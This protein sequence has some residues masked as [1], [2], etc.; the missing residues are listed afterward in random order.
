MAGLEF[1]VPYNNDPETLN[2]IFKL[3][4]MGKNMIREVYLSGPQIYSG[5]GRITLELT[6]NQFKEIIDKIHRHRIRVNLIINPTCEGGD[7]YSRDVVKTK[8]DFLKQMHEEHGLE[9]VTIANPIYVKE[10]RRRFPN[11]EICASVLGDIDSVQR[12]VIYNKLGAN[13]IT[14]D[15][16]INR[17]LDL[18]QKIKSSVDAELKL[19]VNDGCLH[20]CPFRRFHFNYMSH[21][22]KDLTAI[23]GDVFFANCSQITG[24]DHSQIL[25][26]CWIR[27]EDTK[28]YGEITNFFKIVGRARPKSFVIRVVKAY[29]RQSWDGD[30][31]D[32]VS[33]SLN[34]YGI[35]YGAHLDNKSLGK[36]DFFEKVTSSEKHFDKEN[37]FQELADKLIDLKVLTRGK[38]EDLGMKKE[39]DHLKRIGMLN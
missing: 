3:K 30:V 34:K 8:M 20:K 28:K 37:Y 33:G 6:L 13:V 2:D 24:G 35:E 16:D 32:I 18:L 29:L 27:P 26:S 31:L 36:Y 9:A 14:P 39:A 4:K 7:W 10:V 15:V 11:I 17:N 19:M 38:L 23:E 5:S 12:A 25:K 1:S 21:K 22:S